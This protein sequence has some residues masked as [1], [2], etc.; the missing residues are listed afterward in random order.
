MSYFDPDAILCER[1]CIPIRLTSPIFQGAPLR[2]HCQVLE[3]SGPADSP[4]AHA[5]T[6]LNT[7]IWLARGLHNRTHAA[8]V[9]VPLTYTDSALRCYTA[10]GAPGRGDDVSEFFYDVGMHVCSL[11]AP[12]EGEGLKKRVLEVYQRRYF[13]IVRQAV[14]ERSSGLGV[15]KRRKCVRELSL[16][17][18]V[19]EQK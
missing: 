2:Q 3:S 1:E 13:E 16:A 17:Q 19:V 14:G 10:P 18:G 11:L 7:P 6:R 8:V 9:E 15:G 5:S 12:E 4:D